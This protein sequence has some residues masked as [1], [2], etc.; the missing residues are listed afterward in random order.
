MFMSII[1]KYTLFSLQ[2][3]IRI[4]QGHKVCTRTL[5]FNA[6][7]KF[8]KITKFRYKILLS[9]ENIALGSSQILYVFVC[10]AKV[11]TI[12]GFCLDQKL[13]KHANCLLIE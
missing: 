3:H 12:F 1:F 7:S 8:S 6:C 5:Y 4:L 2:G 9:V 10:D 11:V 13:V